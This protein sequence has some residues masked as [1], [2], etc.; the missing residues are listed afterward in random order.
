MKPIIL[1]FLIC[2][3]L[4]AED[5][6]SWNKGIVKSQIEHFIADITDEKSKNF[7]PLNERRAFFDLDGT[8]ICEKPTYVEVAFVLNRIKKK[9]AA[10][11][12]LLY[13]PLY[14]A[15]KNNDTTY[16][17]KNIKEIILE[18]FIGER[19]SFVESQ[20][21]EFVTQQQNSHL[22]TPYI[23]TLYQPMLELI[24]LLKKHHFDVY[25]VSTSQQEYI[26]ALTPDPLP[27]S[28]REIASTMVGFQEEVQNDSIIFVRINKYFTPYCE[29]ENKV[30]RIRER[31]L[32][33]AQVAVGNT[34]GD[35]PM[36]KAVSNKAK[37][38]SLI[39]A[40]NHDDSEREF[41]YID[42]SLIDSVTKYNW[43]AISMK[44][45]FKQIFKLKSAVALD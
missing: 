36:L 8:I 34:M 9:I 14:R 17:N 22:K 5:L 11:K 32:L 44:N 20:A 1:L 6:P 24:S 45:D 26:R 10:D 42:T 23:N 31:A 38:P 40:V 7:V 3:L 37:G 43:I 27:L 4:Y 16:I 29:D 35:Y 30:V 21:Y 2:T 41:S 39:M 33:P 12:T 13:S 15:V 28:K 25:I 18:A 19:L